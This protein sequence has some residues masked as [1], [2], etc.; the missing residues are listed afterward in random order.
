MDMSGE[1]RIEAPREVV[2][3]ALNDLDVLKVCIPG[4]DEMERTGENGFL[5]K[6]TAKIGPVKARFSGEGTLSDIVPPES[7]KITG[8]GKGGP[9]GFAKGGATVNLAEDGTATLLTYEVH[10]NVGGKLA[11]LGG[12]LIQGTA[13]KMA[14]DFFG[15]FA[16]VVAERVAVPPAADVLEPAEN[17]QPPA[18]EQPVD[19]GDEAPAA[20]LVPDAVEAPA[21]APAEVAEVE[22][23]PPVEVEPDARVEVEVAPTETEAP[24]EAETPAEAAEVD[25]APSVEAEPDRPVDAEVAP[26]VGADTTEVAPEPAVDVATD[27][28]AP[29]PEDAVTPPAPTPE[30]HGKAPESPA[31]ADTEGLPPVVWVGAVIAIAVI[32][33]A[34][35]S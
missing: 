8:E 13:K 17:E 29:T 34:V 26:V 14:G 15:R 19:A 20:E 2:W 11:Q 18:V 10:A 24:A 6:V 31:D 23:A 16:E 27:A 1:Q 25:A 22:A 28:S 30:V 12:R 35:F 9:A 21:A 5:A 4:C 7:Y 3:E 33:I 32:L